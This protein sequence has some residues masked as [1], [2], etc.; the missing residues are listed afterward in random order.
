M[1]AWIEERMIMMVETKR[2]TTNKNDQH[3]QSKSV[4]QVVENIDVPP[5]VDR[6][7]EEVMEGM[8]E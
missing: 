8:D 4:M 3:T 5:D 1:P 7:M 2:D 6:P